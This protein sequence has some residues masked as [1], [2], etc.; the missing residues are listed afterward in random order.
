VIILARGGGSL[1]DLWAFNDEGLARAIAACPIPVISAVGHET[2]FTIADFVADVRAPTPSAAAEIAVPVAA[3]LRT[4]VALLGRRA[5]R[6]VSSEL[7]AER[8]QLERLQTRLGDPRRWLDERRQRLDDLLARGSRCLR[9]QIAQRRTQLRAAETGLLR[10]HPQR[11]IADQ[12]AVLARLE[13]R[14][15]AAMTAGLGEARRPLEAIAA[16]L[17]GL[18]PLAVLDRGYGL[19]RRPDGHLVTH[20]AGAVPGDAIEVVL[21]DGSLE[22]RVQKVVPNP[23]PAQTTRLAGPEGKKP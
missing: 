5:A 2:D 11:R 10:A 14:L 19:A 18:S 8:L 9:G 21:A 4:E 1:E 13:R 12:R 20:V 16:K 6:A 22:T 15:A 3:E 23:T 17:E 7:R